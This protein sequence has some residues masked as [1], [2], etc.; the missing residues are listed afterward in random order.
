MKLWLYILLL[1]LYLTIIAILTSYL[2][3][4]TFYLT[5]MT[6]SHN[7][8]ILT[9]FWVYWHCDFLILQFCISCNWKFISQY[10]LFSQNCDSISLIQNCEIINSDFQEKIRILREKV[11]VT[12]L[13]F[14][15]NCKNKIPYLCV[16]PS[17]TCFLF[18]MI[19]RWSVRGFRGL[20]VGTME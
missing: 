12:F 1:S 13:I 20:H 2:V 3:I 6:L 9:Q 5:I 8:I 19:R 11:T 4:K 7:I 18:C 15:S 17:W 10:Q 14:L 16:F